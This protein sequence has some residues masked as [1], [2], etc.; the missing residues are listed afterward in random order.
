MTDTVTFGELLSQ[1]IDEQARTMAGLARPCGVSRSA[2][3]QW[4]SGLTLP[5]VGRLADIDRHLRLTPHEVAELRAA[6]LRSV[7]S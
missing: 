1:Y 2:V 5:R 4:C 6:Y 7:P 3:A